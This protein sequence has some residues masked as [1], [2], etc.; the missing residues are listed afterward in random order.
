MDNRIFSAPGR[1]EVGGNHTDHQRGRVLAAAIDLDMKCQ[2]KINGTDIVN[3]TS[4]GFGSAYVDL[5]DLN[6]RRDERETVASLIRGVAAWFYNNGHTIGGFDGWVSS[7]VP[8]GAGVASSAAFEVMVGNVF[9]GLFNADVSP[10]D[11]ALAGQFAENVYFGK[12]CGLMD[13]AASSF[14]GLS[15]MDFY[16]PKAPVV[17]SIVAD[18]SEYALCVVTTGDSHADLTEDYA[19]IPSEM[20]AIAAYFGK[21][22][23][24][25]VDADEFYSAI[26][27]LRRISDRAVLRAL[28]FF[29]ENERVAR[30]A[31][32][33]DG[34]DIEDFMRL[35]TESGRS[36]L[37]YLQSIYSP[38]NYKEQGLTLALALAER[39][40]NGRGAYRVHGGGFAGSI[41][42]FVPNGLKNDFSRYMSDVFGEGCC[43]YLN[44]RGDGGKEL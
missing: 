16:D 39:V 12:P 13:Q 8:K 24:R 18:F 34:R 38:N 30:Q 33:L 23:L 29:N 42:S 10:L 17:R 35:V 43:R 26:G 3:I 19:A 25:A 1:V 44:I 11:I 28:H 22:D 7:D 37:A 31:E 40:L 41:L 5:K 2:S 15:M 9:K 32:A 20:K 4:E 36:S 21:A 14:G 6:P 27:E